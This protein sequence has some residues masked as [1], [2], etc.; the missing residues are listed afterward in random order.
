MKE[1]VT[2]CKK[3]IKK[4]RKRIQHKKKKKKKEKEKKKK[5][6][7]N[8]SI[9]SSSFCQYIYTA[10]RGGRKIERL[11]LKGGEGEGTKFA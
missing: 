6:F 11:P 9:E 4:S 7:R 5:G 2:K 1:V 3:G 8:T 10:R